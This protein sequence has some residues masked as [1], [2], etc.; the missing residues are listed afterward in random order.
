[1]NITTIIAMLL[2][3]MLLIVALVNRIDGAMLAGG[4]AIIAGLGGYTARRK[5][6]P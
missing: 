3:S 4:I 6:K 1:M 5:L 2:I